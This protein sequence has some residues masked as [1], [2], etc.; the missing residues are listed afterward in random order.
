MTR[1]VG[2]AEQRNFKE[3]QLGANP[4]TTRDE[5]HAID[6]SSIRQQKSDEIDL[7][8]S[9]SIR[10]EDLAVQHARSLQQEVRVLFAR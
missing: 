4:P 2:F 3:V 1:A 5:E 7:P 10:N 9:R 8:S 6:A